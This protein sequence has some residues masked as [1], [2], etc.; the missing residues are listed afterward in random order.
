MPFERFFAYS[1]YHNRPIRLMIRSDGK[2]RFINATVISADGER[3]ICLKA[4]RKT[5]ETIPLDHVLAV[6][7]VRGDSG[8]TLKDVYQKMKEDIK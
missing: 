4:G 7:Y 6:S 5:P 8:D 3:V 2:M 1:I